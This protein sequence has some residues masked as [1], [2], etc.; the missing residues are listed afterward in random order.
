MKINSLEDKNKLNFDEI[1]RL[2][3]KLAGVENHNIQ[4]RR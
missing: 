3:L 2:N 4:L 1:N